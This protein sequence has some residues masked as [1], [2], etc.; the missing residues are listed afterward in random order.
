MVGKLKQPLNHYKQLSGASA[1]AM[2]AKLNLGITYNKDD[3]F[4]TAINKHGDYMAF[5]RV[6]QLPKGA[7]IDWSEMAERYIV[8]KACSIYDLVGWDTTALW[9]AHRGLGS[10]QWL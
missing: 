5:D 10:V 9:N 3:S 1:G 2:W 7:E 6:E 8:K 4:L